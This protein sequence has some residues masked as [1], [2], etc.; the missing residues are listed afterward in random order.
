M[1]PGTQSGTQL[2]KPP[3]ER[4]KELWPDVW[5]LVRP[6]RGL[7]FIGFLLI[8]V[9]TICGFALPLSSRFLFD[10]VI[11]KH[12]QSMLLPLVLIVVGATAL[13]GLTSFALTQLLSMEGQKLIAEL[14]QQVQQ[15]I[16]R[17]SVTFFDANK[18]GQLVS[19]IMSDVEGMR[20]LIGTG[21]IEFIG[22]LMTAAIS[23]FLLLKISAVMTGIAAV[24]VVC[25]GLTL[26]RAFKTI[27]PIFRE[28]GKISAEVTGGLRS[29]SAAFA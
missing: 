28:R 2:K 16:G 6:R 3:S 26:Q 13:Q 20:N 29:R 25:F 21:V 27:R 17:L 11:G 18:T 5:A 22:G 8:I 1:S 10:N 23:L 14:R 9:K 12:Q 15:H 4:L 7:L 24:V 19:R